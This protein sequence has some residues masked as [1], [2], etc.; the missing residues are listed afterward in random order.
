MV[1]QNLAILICLIFILVG[2]SS[3]EEKVIS[4]FKSEIEGKYSIV[5]FDNKVPSGE[6]Q[7]RI[8]KDLID[9]NRLEIPSLSYI[10]V[11]DK[12]THEYDYKKEFSLKRF[13]EIF[14]FDTKGVVLRTHEV[15]E[16]EEF[17]LDKQ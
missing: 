9:K 1:K 6:F 16:L 7:Q 8:H 17:L 12:N 14:V 4:R 2:C 5:I 13:P 15:E 10:M 11:D 3:K